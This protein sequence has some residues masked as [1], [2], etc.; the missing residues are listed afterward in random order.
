M[1]YKYRTVIKYFR[2]ERTVRDDKN[3]GNRYHS[4]LFTTV[5][6]YG[7]RRKDIMILALSS[8]GEQSLLYDSDLKF[9]VFLFL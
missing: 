1:K 3:V 8:V 9:K 5:V 6:L 4:N 2:N 7:R